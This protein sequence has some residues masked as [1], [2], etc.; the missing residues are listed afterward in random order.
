[1][2][3][4][5]PVWVD[6]ASETA[7]SPCV[8]MLV[9]S[10]QVWDN[11]QSQTQK[12]FFKKG[13]LT[14][15]EFICQYL[16]LAMVSMVHAGD[17]GVSNPWSSPQCQPA[18]APLRQWPQAHPLEPEEAPPQ[19][20]M[21]ELDSTN[22]CPERHRR[23]LENGK[24]MGNHMDILEHP[25]KIQVLEIVSPMK[26]MISPTYM[27]EFDLPAWVTIALMWP[28]II[29]V[30]VQWRN[31]V[32][33]FWYPM[34]RFDYPKYQRMISIARVVLVDQMYNVYTRFE[35]KT[36]KLSRNW[37]CGH[38]WGCIGDNHETYF[39]LRCS[40]PGILSMCST[41][42]FPMV[43]ALLKVM[44]QRW[45]SGPQG[46][47]RRHHPLTLSSVL[48]LSTVRLENALLSIVPAMKR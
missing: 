5:A 29:T 39:K 17:I 14:V 45:K 7:S 1:M 47:A 48:W 40:F 19:H 23:P 41:V 11:F 8:G 27:R 16:T 21:D 3:L 34:R 31:H 44:L 18:T 36:G 30:C 20:A 6:K 15:G 46:T 4:S 22:R 43:L 10:R 37:L 24:I 12:M 33:P 38:S 26:T 32:D 35:R 25:W 2:R 13:Q 9:G 42:F 28:G